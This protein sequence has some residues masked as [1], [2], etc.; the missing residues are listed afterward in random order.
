MTVPL[1][2]GSAGRILPGQR[3]VEKGKLVAL[4]DA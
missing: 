1:R 4:A 2:Q 3:A